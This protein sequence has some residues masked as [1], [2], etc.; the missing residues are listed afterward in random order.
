MEP[1]ELTVVPLGSNRGAK[2]QNSQ[3][4]TD[5]YEGASHLHGASLAGNMSSSQAY[6]S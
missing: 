2:E 5:G 1:I 3:R 4:H 6:S